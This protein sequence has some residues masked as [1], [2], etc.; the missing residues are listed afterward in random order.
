MN[1]ESINVKEALADVALFRKALTGTDQDLNESRLVGITLKANFLIQGG[2]F[3]LVG[4]IFIFEMV[5]GFLLTQTL[6]SGGQIPELRH[7]GIALIGLI[8]GG[9]VFTLYFVVWRAAKHNGDKVGT[10]ILRNFR[11]LNHLSFISDLLIKFMVI[12]LI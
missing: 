4:V 9:L 5:S 1:Q 2:I 8:V 11:Y 12:S 6:M 7:T 10:Y 3:F